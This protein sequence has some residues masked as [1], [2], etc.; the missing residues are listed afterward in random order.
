[1]SER[2]EQSTHSNPLLLSIF[3]I[4]WCL[5]LVSSGCS[6]QLHWQRVVLEILFSQRLNRHIHSMQQRGSEIFIHDR[7]SVIFRGWFPSQ[8]TQNKAYLLIYFP[9]FLPAVQKSHFSQKILHIAHTHTKQKGRRKGIEGIPLWNHD[10]RTIRRIWRS[11]FSK[12][13]STLCDWDNKG[14]ENSTVSPWSW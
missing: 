14:P 3:L 5:N 12:S 13:S 1:M 4:S 7:S 9:C 2:R 11:C 10:F 8:I 6:S